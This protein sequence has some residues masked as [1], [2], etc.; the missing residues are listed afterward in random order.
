MMP[1]DFSTLADVMELQQRLLS[2]LWDRLAELEADAT[3]EAVW[4]RTD[5]DSITGLQCSA[6]HRI[7]FHQLVEGRCQTCVRVAIR[8]AKANEEE[9]LLRRQLKRAMA[10][11]TLDLALLGNPR[12]R[13]RGSR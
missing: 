3:R 9:R 1:T 5:W 2:V 8:W 12:W 13:P 4:Q 6:C 7:V 10:L 11:G